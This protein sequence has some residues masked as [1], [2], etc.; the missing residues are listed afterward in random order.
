MKQGFGKYI[1]GKVSSG[2]TRGAMDTA[3][4]SGRAVFPAAPT[5]LSFFNFF[6]EEPCFPPSADLFCTKT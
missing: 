2:F 5:T 1:T 3:L 6:I 4:A